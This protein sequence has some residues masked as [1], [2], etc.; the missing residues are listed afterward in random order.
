MDE[1]G[2]EVVRLETGID[3]PTFILGATVGAALGHREER[4]GVQS[5]RQR[6]VKRIVQK[7]VMDDHAPI[8]RQGRGGAIQEEPAFGDVPI[9]EDVRQE[10]NIGVARKRI[11]EHIARAAFKPI[12]DP[13]FF[14]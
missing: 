7:N 14:A 4:R 2:R 10:M 5:D 9:V 11:G 13:V 12:G 6:A 1:G 3:Q 8:F